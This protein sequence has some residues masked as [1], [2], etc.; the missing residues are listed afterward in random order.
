MRV[1]SSKD[2]LGCK[3]S[4]PW[5]LI[6][7]KVHL[8]PQCISE[9]PAPDPLPHGSLLHFGQ[10]LPTQTY[11]N[12]IYLHVH[13]HVQLILTSLF[14]YFYFKTKHV[15]LQHLDGPGKLWGHC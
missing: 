5:E 9:P 8:A 1:H 11:S 2:S 10:L 7:S 15:L 14:V 4:H 3:A 6:P 12:P 13:V